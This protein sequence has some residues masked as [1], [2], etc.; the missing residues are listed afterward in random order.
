MNAFVIDTSVTLAWYFNESFSPSAREWQ[1]RLLADR[2]RLLTPTLHYCEF[3]NALRTRVVRGEL[4]QELA[5][6]ILDIHLDAP[7]ESIDPDRRSVMKA[8]LEYGATAYDAVFI[9]LALDCAVPMITAER[10][11]TTWVTRLGKL[12]ETVR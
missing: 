3:M 2:V 4:P 8:S 12:V 7:L 1:E 9:A 5:H 11:T 10:T 6:E